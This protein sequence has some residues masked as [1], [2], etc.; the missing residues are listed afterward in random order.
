M[1]NGAGRGEFPPVLFQGPA[2]VSWWKNCAKRDFFVPFFSVCAWTKMSHI[3]LCGM[4]VS[5]NIPFSWDKIFGFCLA[6]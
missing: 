1:Q 2:G 6:F 4:A 5:N 3:L